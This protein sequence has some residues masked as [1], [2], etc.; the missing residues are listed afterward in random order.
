MP[1]CFSYCVRFSTVA[2]LLP[3]PFFGGGVY[4][5]DLPSPQSARRGKRSE[6]GSSAHG[7]PNC[8]PGGFDTEQDGPYANARSREPSLANTIGAAGT[9]QRLTS[10]QIGSP[11]KQRE[12]VGDAVLDFSVLPPRLSRSCTMQG[13]RQTT[14]E[15]CAAVEHRSC[16]LNGKSAPI[17]P[18]PSTGT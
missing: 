14:L 17:L 10:T 3:I 8:R 2:S 18:D 4:A 15:A 16:V 9:A 5:R 7:A 1:N 11:P 13:N 12:H 6:I